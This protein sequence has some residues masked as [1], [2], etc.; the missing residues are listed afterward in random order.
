MSK[1]PFEIFGLTP[2]MVGML[3][4][5]ELFL[6][7]KSMYRALQKTVHPD[8]ARRRPRKNDADRA[9]ELNLA[10]EALNL[11]KNPVA[12]RRHRK[13]FVSRRPRLIYQKSLA[14]E[15]QI[16]SQKIRED[17]L[18]EAYLERLVTDHG[19]PEIAKNESPAMPF[20]L[21]NVRL[22]LLDVAINQNLKMASWSLGSNYKEINFD[23]K[24]QMTV[25]PVGRN[26]FS[27]AAYIHLL[28]SV[29]M[30]AAQL[31]PLLDR[32]PAKF[33]KAPALNGSIGANGPAISVLNRIC[34]DNFKRHVL[35]HLKP[36][37]TERSYLFSLNRPEFEETG[38]LTLEG[39]VVKIEGSSG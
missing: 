33:F 34:Q 25:R 19:W 4:E 37:V 28:G 5:K 31:L 36:Q 3:S 9:V 29:E 27:R 8:V 6:V 1:N 14:L 32:P 20:P 2:D 13:S 35:V 10:F 18:A 21:K 22:G 17:R 11:D 15:Q 26:R 12:F 23:A 39:Q 30:E 24:G 16:L 38:G 7:L